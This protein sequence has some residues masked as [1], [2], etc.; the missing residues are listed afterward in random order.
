VIRL[1]TVALVCVA[2]AATVH[3]NPRVLIIGDSISIGYTKP[4][5]AELESIAEVRRIPGNAGHTGMG[6]EGLPKWLDEKNGKWDVI[7]FNWGLWDLCYRNPNSKTQGRR[8]KVN[9]KI[10]HTVEQYVENLAKIVTILEKTGAELIFA[11]TT[12]VP[13]GEAG[14]KVGD[15]LRY[16]EA[17][18]ALM[19]ERGVAINDLHSFILPRMK[20]L[21][22][23]PGNVH[24]TK[25]GSK[26][27]AT[28]VAERVRRT[29]DQR[30]SGKRKKGTK[31]ASWP[32]P[33]KIE[34][35]KVGET[36][37]SLHVFEPAGHRPTDK[38]AAIVLFF[39]GG[40]NGGSPAQFYPHSE[41]LAS[42][43]MVAISAEYR[44]KSRHR[45]TPFDCVA[46]GKSALRFVRKNAARL[47]IDPDRIA[48]GGGSAGGHVAAAVA[49]VP[50]LDTDT[51]RSI[52]CRPSA[53]VLYNPV[54]DNGP[55]GYGHDRVKDR[56][57]EIS[58]MHNIAKGM[59]ATLVFLGTQ[60]KL[61]PVATGEAF[62][63]KMRE[64]GSRSELELFEDRRHGFFN[65]GRG[66]GSDYLQTVRS[67][68]VFLA[69]LGHLEGKPTLRT[70]R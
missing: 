16:N 67:M 56:F 66:D 47:G 64:V 70:H 55:K 38:P 25:E 51:D 29:L 8:D 60:D 22:T 57:R 2:L 40:W 9:G 49:T 41:Y 5:I 48:A 6:L 28:R 68:D 42:R 11:T 26:L 18:V 10:T 50:G 15:D 3:A 20:E 36:S 52:S 44:V 19:R 58:P 37:L 33:K 69:S 34:Y 46:D 21:A 27:L 59:P 17:A 14:R 30:F 65:H 62:R 12:P 1:T 54:Y 43:G 63:D 7:H 32:E 31:R 39:G 61:I 45:T 24:F 53:L 13:D 35:K 4:V 23:K